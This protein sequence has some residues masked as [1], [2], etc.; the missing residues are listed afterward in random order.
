MEMEPAPS[1]RAEQV[2]NPDPIIDFMNAG[3]LAGHC[4]SHRSICLWLWP[5]ITLS[6]GWPAAI[7]KHWVR[8]KLLP[9][10]NGQSRRRQFR[11]NLRG[12][13][14]LPCIMFFSS[15]RSGKILSLDFPASRVWGSSAHL[16]LQELLSLFS[17]AAHI[18]QDLPRWQL[19]IHLC[20][21]AQR[22]ERTAD[23]RTGPWASIRSSAEDEQIGSDHKPSARRWGGCRRRRGPS[24][25]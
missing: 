9:A 5:G 19:N 11:Q 7:G 8:A 25:Q 15:S 20:W 17:W 4:R 1:T 21:A 24:W 3:L 22:Q 18:L 6:S 14:F 13:Y 23:L 12:L 2:A 10:S 16:S